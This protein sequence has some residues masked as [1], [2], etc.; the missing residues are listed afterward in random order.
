MKIKKILPIYCGV[1]AKIEAAYNNTFNDSVSLINSTVE[2]ESRSDYF[3]RKYSWN[4]EMG[5]QNCPP[6]T[7]FNSE[8]DQPMT[9]QGVYYPDEGVGS[10]TVDYAKVSMCFEE[11]V[12]NYESSAYISLMVGMRNIHM[13]ILIVVNI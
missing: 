13:P 8:T 3:K 4:I 6:T 11:K 7:N 10:N 2:N 1:Q 9:Y 5:R 12:Y